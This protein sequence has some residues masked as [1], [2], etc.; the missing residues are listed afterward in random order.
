METPGAVA[1]LIG[2]EEVHAH[3]ALEGPGADALYV[4]P[5]RT[6]A[7]DGEG[8]LSDESVSEI[9]HDAERVTV[10][11]GRRKATIT[12]SY[13]L[14]G[15]RS[16][17][18]PAP[19]VEAALHP[20][21]AGVLAARGITEEDETIGHTYRFSEL[22]LV[23]TSHRVVKH[24][25]S[26]VWDE[27]EHE[28]IALGDVR[29]LGI[30]EGDVSTQIVI[31]TTGRQERIKTPAEGAR[32]VHADIEDAL[33]AY[34]GVGSYEQFRE[35]V[36]AEAVEDADAAP[37]AGDATGFVESGL[38]PISISGADSSA[39][40]GDTAADPPE[41]PTDTSDATAD[42]SETSVD[43]GDTTTGS[44][45]TAA[46]SV[47]RST[48]GSASTATPDRGSEPDPERSGTVPAADSGEEDDATAD[49]S[50]GFAGSPFESAATRQ[51]PDPEAVE[52]ELRAL[53]NALARQA[54]LIEGQR[55]AVE[56]LLEELDL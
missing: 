51:A 30:E 24:V 43:A 41:A 12:L 37:R 33:L 18:V 17:V 23:V 19:Q 9:P 54:D 2:E 25:G 32:Q 52:A 28:E 50:G 26:A 39:A 15:D 21:L 5:T 48:D 45:D 16:V 46:E 20:L 56:A 29:D 4:T 38:D 47:E 3:V 1:E 31:E 27:A 42:P 6:V 7:Y 40:A 13:G 11:E 44:S 22:T 55:A 10:S 35:N 14:D 49:E 36:T 34:H 8:L 53:D